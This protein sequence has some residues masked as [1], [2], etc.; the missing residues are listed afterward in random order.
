LK[1]A[2]SEVARITSKKT[3]AEFVENEAVEVML[4]NLGIDYAQGYLVHRPAANAQ[5]FEAC[6]VL[7]P[8][9]GSLQSA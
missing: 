5:M 3:I 2:V 4:K 6:E 7:P 9:L 8:Y 1:A